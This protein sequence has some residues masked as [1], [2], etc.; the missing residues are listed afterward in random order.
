MVSDQLPYK[1]YLGLTELQGQLYDNKRFLLEEALFTMLIKGSFILFLSAANRC[2]YVFIKLRHILFGIQMTRKQNLNHLH[3]S[4]MVISYEMAAA[5]D[6]RATKQMN[7][8][9]S[10]E[11][12]RFAFFMQNPL[13]AIYISIKDL[14]CYILYSSTSAFHISSYT[15]PCIFY[16][17]LK[18][19]S[20]V[21]QLSTP[22]FYL[23]T[24]VFLRF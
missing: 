22:F 6:R 9:P 21:Q 13:P 24:S 16:H 20:S 12:I 7:S 4:H 15:V 2:E 14:S 23:D 3:S 5:T 8:I 1:G 10:S 18:I 17:H 11:F 19:S